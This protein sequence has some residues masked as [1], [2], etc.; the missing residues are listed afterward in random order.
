MS[1]YHQHAANFARQYESVSA[2]QVHQ[3]WLHLLTQVPSKTA[4]DVGAGSGRDARFLASQGFAV[5]AV[6][7]ADALRQ[8]AI[9]LT[10]PSQTEQQPP[11]QFLA[12]QLPALPHVQALNQRFGLILL[13]AVWMHLPHQ[14]RADALP[15]LAQLLAPQGLLVLTLRHG[16]FSDGREAFP[17]A[18]AEIEDLI[19][20]Q[21]LPL[22]TLL[23]TDLVTDA[24]GRG[25]VAWQTVVL[26][27]GS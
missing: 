27:R 12:D 8:L 7:P 11:I 4:L 14:Q 19:H 15:G 24:L 6:E 16:S 18:S 10:A 21:Q 2:E 25:D 22:R 1:I 5:V 13:S 17:V 3:S 20:Q 23:V 9:E 26:Q